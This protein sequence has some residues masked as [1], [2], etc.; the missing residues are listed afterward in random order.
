GVKIGF[1]RF[2][3]MVKKLGLLGKQDIGVTPE[4]RGFV[5]F[6]DWNKTIQM[7][8]MGFGQSINVTPLGL[9]S[10]FTVFANDGKRVP[11]RLIKKIDGEE[12]TT[13]HSV[14][15]FKPAIAKE[16]LHLME[17]VIESGHGTGKDLKIKGYTLAGKTGTAQ[18]LGS[19]APG[20]H[21]VSSFVGYVPAR[22][23]RVVVLVMIDDPKAN[24][25]YG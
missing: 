2:T 9:A 3:A 15:I 11:P 22:N 10:A 4:T 17:A 21:Y 14:Q 20:R 1:E 19:A 25:F 13:G 5:N 12:T 6:S 16:M 18:K 8:N 7:A 24:G 23:P